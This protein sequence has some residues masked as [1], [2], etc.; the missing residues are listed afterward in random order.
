MNQETAIPKIS[1]TIPAK[2]TVTKLMTL[3]EVADLCRVSLSTVRYW[4]VMG[5]LKTLKVGKH[6]L[7]LQG[8]LFEFLGLA[9][10]GQR[11]GAL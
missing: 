9:P 8:D 5:R 1:N 3:T 6:P 11:V 10:D 7:V 2:N 4:K